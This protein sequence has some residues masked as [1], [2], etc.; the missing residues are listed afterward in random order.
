MTN[1]TVLL[2][3]LTLTGSPVAGVACFAWCHEGPA[4]HSYCQHDP[5]ASSGPVIDQA[6]NCTQ[7]TLVADL[8]PASHRAS[9]D[10]AIFSTTSSAAAVPI[11]AAP[12]RAETAP[13]IRGWSRLPV[14][15]RI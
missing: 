15:L 3:V 4:A 6:V 13:P 8:F 5:A 1:I 12:A 10:A 9:A 11:V 7:P 14:V 2:L